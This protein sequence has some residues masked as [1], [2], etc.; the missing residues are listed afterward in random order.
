[1]KAKRYFDTNLLIAHWKRCRK[2]PLSAYSR[3]D[4]STWARKL[5]ELHQTN[6]ILTPV[7]IEFLCGTMNPHELELSRAYLEEFKILDDGKILESDWQEAK[8]FAA[9]VTRDGKRRDL[10][11]C[12]LKA[13]AQRLGHDPLT[14]D[15]DHQRRSNSSF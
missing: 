14:G 3:I 1:M 9:W 8:R 12:L 2:L 15:L 11:D 10:A 4:A 13:I 5:I 6:V 7:A